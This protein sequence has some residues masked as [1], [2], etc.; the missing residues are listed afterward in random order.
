[1]Y[2]CICNGVTDKE[3]KEAVANGATQLSDLQMNLGVATC[4]GKCA[5]AAC[6]FLPNPNP[7]PLVA[8]SQ[9]QI[10]KSK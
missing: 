1:M 6:S 4:C 2:I 3:I 5:D 7:I 10:L 8:N 9:V